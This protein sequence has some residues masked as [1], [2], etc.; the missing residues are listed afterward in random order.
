[1]SSKLDFVLKRSATNVI[2]IDQLYSRLS[3]LESQVRNIE[4]YVRSDCSTL[5]NVAFREEALKKSIRTIEA[6]VAELIRH[7]T[8]ALFAPDQIWWEKK[9]YLPADDATADLNFAA[10]IAY[11]RKKFK[12]SP[13]ELEEWSVLTAHTVS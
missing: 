2:S 3:Q 8:E 4:H 10:F 9:I 13:K 11:M 7:E 12:A 6:D 5:G 1:M